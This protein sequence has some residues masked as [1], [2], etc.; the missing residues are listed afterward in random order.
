MRWAPGLLESLMQI[1]IITVGNEILSGRTVD[2]NFAFLA[3]ALEA[4]SVQVAWHAAVGDQSERIAEAHQTGGDAR[5]LVA[6]IEDARRFM[7]H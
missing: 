7:R 6:G 5:V 4:A 1:E 3:R 2:T